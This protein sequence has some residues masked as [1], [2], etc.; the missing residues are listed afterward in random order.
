MITSLV[1]Q[2]ISVDI[3]HKLCISGTKQSK[4]WN[5][6]KKARPASKSPSLPKP[7]R[8]FPSG[9]FN[10]YEYSICL[11]KGKRDKHYDSHHQW[12]KE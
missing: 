6:M 5:V 7:K 8:D 10:A 1:P 12:L 11:A 4:I 9:T 2:F 3:F